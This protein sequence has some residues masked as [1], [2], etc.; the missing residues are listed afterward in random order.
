MISKPPNRQQYAV[1]FI[2]IASI[3]LVTI[4]VGIYGS[5]NLVREVSVELP[6]TAKAQELATE[7][8]KR[9][10]SNSTSDNLQPSSKTDLEKFQGTWIF[11]SDMIDGR[12]TDIKD[13][14]NI[15]VIVTGETYIITEDGEIITRATFKI[16]PSYSSPCLP[17]VF[18]W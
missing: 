18:A 8:A 15:Q 3:C 7:E 4:G 11:V 17:S 12:E 16:D 9:N 13:L 6:A 5:I 1:I 2:V 10:A 14:A